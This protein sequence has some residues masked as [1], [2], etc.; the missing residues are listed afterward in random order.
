MIRSTESCPSHIQEGRHIR[1]PLLPPP[2]HLSPRPA[3]PE[4]GVTQP[5]LSSCSCHEGQG[6]GQHNGWRTS[7]TAQVPG[8]RESP[9]RQR[10]YQAQLRP[11][12]V[13]NSF[14][15]NTLIRGRTAQGGGVFWAPE[16]AEA[17]AMGFKS[18]FLPCKHWYTNVQS[19]TMHN[20]QP[21]N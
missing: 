5:L 10:V 13:L 1:T 3:S 14:P 16:A 21:V 2:K 9:T 20:C 18:G 17:L 12:A 4:F 19:S 11:W 15:P 8:A 6:E 7:S